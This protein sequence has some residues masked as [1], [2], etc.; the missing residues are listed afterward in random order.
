MCDGIADLVT[1]VS[2]P[3]SSMASQIPRVEP[4]NVCICHKNSENLGFHYVMEQKQTLECETSPGV[5][6]S[7]ERTIGRTHDRVVWN[8]KWGK[9]GENRTE[10]YKT[11]SACGQNGLLARNI[12]CIVVKQRPSQEILKKVLMRAAE[13]TWPSR[14][15][16]WPALLPRRLLPPALPCPCLL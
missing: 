1:R 2:A 16:A 10:M 12:K 13:T 14:R 7:L 5:T 6:P 9:K 3:V 11:T 15:A 4:Y 8:I